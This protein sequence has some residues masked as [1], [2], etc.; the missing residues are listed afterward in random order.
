MKTPHS[1]FY[2]MLVA[3]ALILAGVACGVPA[4]DC[5]GT[6]F[7]VKGYIINSENAPVPNAVVRAWNNEPAFESVVKTDPAG[8]F[9]T[10]SLFSYSCY[11]FQIDVSAEGYESTSVTSHPYVFT[12]FS[13]EITIQLE[14]TS[15]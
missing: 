7:T 10:E 11:S 4:Q 8:F 15:E 9:E 5:M 12:E 1:S 13:E 6:T 3:L 14:A 2:V